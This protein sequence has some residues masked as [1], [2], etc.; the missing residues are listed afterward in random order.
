ML[1]PTG[2]IDLPAHNGNGGFD[3]ADVHPGS[4]RMYIAHTANNCVDVIDTRKGCYTHSIPGLRGVAG[5]LVAARR[6]L[7][8]TSNRQDD[9]VGIFN[10][11]CE[12]KMDLARVGIRPNGLAYDERHDLLLAAT[13]GDPE[14][15]GPPT[16]SLLDVDTRRV[17]A[18]LPVAGRTRWATYDPGTDAFY[19][20]IASPAQIAVIQAQ[21][22]YRI[23][24][25]IDV[26]VAGPHGLGLDD[27]SARLFCACD[28]GAL[29][30]LSL[31]AGEVMNMAPLSGVPDVVFF[32][33]APRRIYIAV[34][35]PGVIDVVDSDT[36]QPLETIVT[37]RGAHTFALDG[38]THK[39]Y[40]LLPATHRAM[41]LSP[42]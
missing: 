18:D 40:A 28:G 16:L 12:S 36:L 2:F 10:P 30:A 29:V 26:P 17:V 34:G 8:F 37:E 27:S 41:V 31:P 13:V 5:V 14:L 20:N 1:M 22:P 33:P 42:Q 21:D 35:N 38:V 24:R 6:G 23:A 11:D 19:V 15:S 3:H 39:L 4:G 32:D 7:V 9:S 25:H